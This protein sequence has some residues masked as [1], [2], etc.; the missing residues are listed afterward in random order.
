MTRSWLIDPNEVV[1]KVSKSKEQNKKESWNGRDF[2]GNVDSYKNVS[3]WEDCQKYNFISAGGGKWYSN[4]LK[5][6][7]PGARLFAMIPK[8]G[9][10]GVGIIKERAVPIKDFM[11]DHNGENVSIIK[12]PLRVEG[13]KKDP[14]DLDKCEYF[15]KVE[16][17]KTVPESKALW[18]K[19]FLA[20]NLEKHAFLIRTK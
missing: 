14:D 11:V 13:V 19:G 12:V 7:F 3:T 8:K 20:R 5:Q 16:W 4:S 1:E 15:V 18:K 17:L 2:V 9:Y 10:V 6:L